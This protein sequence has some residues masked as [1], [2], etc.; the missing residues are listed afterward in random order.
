MPDSENSAE[1]PEISVIIVNYN[2]R[3]FLEQALESVQKALNSLNGEIIVVDNNSAD[4]SVKMLREKWL[5]VKLIANTENTGFSKANNQ[6]I[7]MAHGKYVL[8]LNPDT[9]IR[10]DTL[11]KSLEFMR[12]RPDAGALGVKMI[13]GSGAYLPES[14]RGFPSPWVAFCKA[15]GLSRLFPRSALFNRYHVGYLSPD[16]NHAVDVLSGAFMLIPRKVLDEVG[17]LDEDFFMYGEDIDLSYRIVKAG[18]R[19]YYFADTTIIHYKGESTKKGSL[20][21]VRTFYNAMII[22]ARKHLK[23]SNAGLFIAMLQM[24]IYFRASISL[25]SS[26]AKKLMWP[27][28]DALI[29]YV[30]LVAVKDLWASQYFQNPGMFD[31]TVYYI[32]FPLYVSVWL[33]SIYF[34]GAYDKQYSMRRLLRGLFVGTVII[35]AIYGF[36][37]AEYRFSRAVI[38]LGAL[39]ATLGTMT[40]RYAALFIRT[41]NLYPGQ[42]P[43]NMV[44]VGTLN[45]VKRAR[46][47]L[48]QVQASK[49]YIGHITPSGTVTSDDALGPIDR[50]DDIVRIYNIQEVIFCSADVHSS[51]IMQWMT[52]LGPAI[53]YKILPEMSSSII[54][55]HSS[56]SQGELYT[57]DIKFRLQEPL[58]RRNKRLADL[59]IAFVLLLLLPLH[60]AFI[61]NKS[62]FFRN[63]LKVIAGNK[64]W[65]AYAGN[66]LPANLP[67]I[68]KGVLSPIDGIRIKIL[69]DNTVQRLNLLYAKDYT[70]YSDLNILFRGFKHL[71]RN[72]D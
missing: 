4:D 5:D 25:A 8:L 63:L 35:A 28:A 59:V 68:K 17:W 52:K 24:A 12:S 60:I 16:E 47:L 46:E 2:V 19:N 39:A 21:Y 13:D 50:L 23:S 33:I 67:A 66:E 9:V 36:L 64:T 51:A 26:L 20:N 54:G 14:K 41:G 43:A 10:E 53:Q 29:L 42:K 61:H 48:L 56:G 55:S 37:D 30:G 1:Q 57:I 15:F 22:F 72:T 65:V 31:A 49:N 11:V 58:Q 69:A 27:V 34:S 3:Y 62:G 71:G 7:S 70:I 44:I 45:E 6:G 40:L 18:Y 38:V 32:N